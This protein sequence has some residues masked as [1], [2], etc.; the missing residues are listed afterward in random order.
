MAS[1]KALHAGY[2]IDHQLSH[3][4]VPSHHRRLSDKLLIVFH[5]ACDAFDL[6]PAE[7]L[8]AMIETME[9]GHILP[10]GVDRRVTAESLA[11]ARDRL[12]TL[13]EMLLASPT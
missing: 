3:P 12:K 5:H 11:L 1:I 4:R 8:L 6:E 2:V 9:A 7:R 10:G 13:R